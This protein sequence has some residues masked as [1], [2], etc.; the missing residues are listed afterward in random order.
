MHTLAKIE[1]SVAMANRI[2]GGVFWDQILR[3]EKEN[4]RHLNVH[5]VHLVGDRLTK[6][7][8]R[9]ENGDEED[10]GIDA[11][12]Q[13]RAISMPNP[14]GMTTTQFRIMCRFITPINANGLVGFDQIGHIVNELPIVETVENIFTD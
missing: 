1:L 5:V 7:E 13:L 6:Y 11:H 2:V 9:L 8:T 3:I 10:P 12:T 14:K 4:R